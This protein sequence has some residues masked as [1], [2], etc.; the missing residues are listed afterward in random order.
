MG[1]IFGVLPMGQHPDA[2]SQ[3]FA[4]EPLDQLP[5]GV[6]RP[7]QAATDQGGVVSGHG[8]PFIR[9]TPNAGAEFH[10]PLFAGST[11]KI[12]RFFTEIAKPTNVRP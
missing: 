9:T 12:V 10:T 8:D 6:R 7:F 11:L 4:L 2:E 3:D 5:H 1:D